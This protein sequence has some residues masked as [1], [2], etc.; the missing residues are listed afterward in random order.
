MKPSD[1]GEPRFI[2]SASG[3]VAQFD[4]GFDVQIWPAHGRTDRFYTGRPVDIRHEGRSF[5]AK[6][7]QAIQRAAMLA[8][9][10][11]AP[12]DIHVDNDGDIVATK[13]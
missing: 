5:A 13:K 1:F 2:E 9:L 8:F 7:R 3:V 4:N 6:G 11:G 12:Y 10:S